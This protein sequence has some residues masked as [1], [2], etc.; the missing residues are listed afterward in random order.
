M[1]FGYP[2]WMTYGHLAVAAPAGLAAA[3]LFRR[4]KA[5]ALKWILVVV[6]GWALAAFLVAKLGFR[7]DAP[8]SP[9]TARFLA[10]GSGTVLDMGCGSG[11]ASIGLLR[12][13]PRATVV[14]LDNW[15]ADYIRGNGPELL[16]ANARAAGVDSRLSA[17]SADMRELPFEDGTFDAVMSAYAV[18]HLD[19]P[20]IMR[21]LSEAVRV[22][23]P[24]G[25]LLLLNMVGDGWTKFAY[26][27]LLGLHASGSSRASH[28]GGGHGSASSGPSWRGLLEHLGLEVVEVGRKPGTL[29]LLARKP[30]PRV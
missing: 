9:P 23:K 18:D 7:L 1:N 10:S 14:G 29:F 27:P 28:G 13:R 19:G 12:A 26:T 4:R 3:W 5:K 30:G 6:A 16:L 22:L 24:G 21:A 17:R 25:E 8:V 20:G 11:R 2:W 15:S